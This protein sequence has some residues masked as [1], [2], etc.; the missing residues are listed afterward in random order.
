MFTTRFNVGKN[1]AHI[2]ITGYAP[3]RR[4]SLRSV[5]AV[6]ASSSPRGPPVSSSSSSSLP[7]SSISPPPPRAAASRRASSR[8]VAV[9]LAS[10][11]R[12]HAH[13]VRYDAPHRDVEAHQSKRLRGSSASRVDPAPR[14]GW[15]QDPRAPRHGRERAGDAPYHGVEPPHVKGSRRA[16][17]ASVLSRVAE[18][19]RDGARPQDGREG[20][21]LQRERLRRAR[22]GVPVGHEEHRPRRVPELRDGEPEDEL[23]RERRSKVRRVK[24]HR[25]DDDAAEHGE[26]AA[27]EDD[28]RDGLELRPGEAR[29][30]LEA[31]ARHRTHPARVASRRDRARAELMLT[32][33]P[34][35]AASASQ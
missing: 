10:R 26:D 18:R 34:S 1:H 12:V 24:E 17:R 3:R 6:A 31:L 32:S 2:R 14:P 29:D 15:T 13:L 28:L 19:V 27:G 4:R 9:A 22:R 5:A 30:V 11:R 25:D 7:L 35:R 23:E 33:C 8:I 20:E 21:E 16:H